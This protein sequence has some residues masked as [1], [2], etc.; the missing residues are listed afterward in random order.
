MRPLHVALAFLGL[1]PPVS[2]WLE[3]LGLD[4]REAR[5]D[6]VE[7]LGMNAEVTFGANRHEASMAR[8][9]RARAARRSDNPLAECPLESVLCAI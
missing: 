9:E 6:T 5:E 3:T 7:I 8:G 1:G 4:A 2:T